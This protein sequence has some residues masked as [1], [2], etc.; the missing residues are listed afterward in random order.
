[1]TRKIID[2]IHDQLLEI[3]LKVQYRC[4]V[5]ESLYFIKILHTWLKNYQTLVML[6]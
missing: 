4:V 5:M 6:K 3:H 1:M 2:E